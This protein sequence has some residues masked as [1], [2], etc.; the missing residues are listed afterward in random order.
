MKSRCVGSRGL[1][2]DESSSERL[3][4]ISRDPLMIAG[5]LS[6]RDAVVDSAGTCPQKSSR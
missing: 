4:A 5:E 6:R 1:G 2:V 3:L